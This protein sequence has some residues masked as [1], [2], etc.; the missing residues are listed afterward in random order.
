M[1]DYDFYMMKVKEEITE[2]I[3][4]EYPI[5]TKPELDQ[6]VEDMLATTRRLIGNK[7]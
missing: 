7:K 5:I 1:T 6:K 4:E 2:K 3:K